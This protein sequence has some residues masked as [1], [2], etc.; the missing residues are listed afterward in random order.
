MAMAWK[1]PGFRSGEN[2]TREVDASWCY[3]FLAKKT[4]QK[5]KH[6]EKFSIFFENRGSVHLQMLQL[7][8]TIFSFYWHITFNLTLPHLPP[9]AECALF[10]LPA[11]NRQRVIDGFG[12]VKIC[13]SFPPGK[14]VLRASEEAGVGWL[15]WWELS[16]PTLTWI[17]SRERIHIPPE[18][19]G[20]SSTQ[21]CILWWIC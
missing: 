2:P 19:G 20:K 12:D 9:V 10:C 13:F 6:W 8:P 1:A 5:L 7:L 16:F 3:N 21:K 18:K 11:I 14:K 15:G 4:L 17:P